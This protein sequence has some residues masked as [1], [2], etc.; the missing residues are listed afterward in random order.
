MMSPKEYR[1]S[2]RSSLPPTNVKRHGTRECTGREREGCYG[3]QH[4]GGRAHPFDAVTSVRDPEHLLK[5]SKNR[6]KGKK[7]CLL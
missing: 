6:E 5:K 1:S 7:L 2:S 4:E 3:Q